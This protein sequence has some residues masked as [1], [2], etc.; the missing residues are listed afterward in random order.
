MADQVKENNSL[1]VSASPHIRD[2]ESIPRI[3]WGVALSLIPAGIAG[4]LYLGITAFTSS[5]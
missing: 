1:I 2:I 4:P 3:M 5:F